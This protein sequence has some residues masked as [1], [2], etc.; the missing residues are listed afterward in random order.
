MRTYYDWAKTD[1]RFNASVLAAE[2]NALQEISME[3]AFTVTPTVLYDQAGAAILVDEDTWV[4]CGIEY[5][6]DVPHVS[7]VVTSNGFSDWSTTRWE[8]WDNP[9]A[10]LGERQVTLKL[11]V[12]KTIP[13]EEQGPAVYVEVVRPGEQD[14][15]DLVR[16]LPFHSGK[17]AWRMGPFTA[18]PTLTDED[19]SIVFHSILITDE[20][21]PCLQC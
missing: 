9:K 10:P 7:V 14:Q 3:L 18:G 21:P 6:D 1:H 20:V 19:K 12:T 5:F 17:K 15:W 11:R 16:L 4:K 8:H 2:I 13:S